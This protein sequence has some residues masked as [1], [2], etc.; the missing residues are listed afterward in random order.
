MFEY[1]T[2]EETARIWGVT[3]RYV[4]LLCKNGKIEGAVK[5]AGSW[6]IPQDAQNPE[7]KRRTTGVFDSPTKNAIFDKAIELV[8]LYRYEVVTIKDIAREIGRNQATIYNHFTSKQDILDQIYDYYCKYFNYDRSTIDEL[9]P[10]MRSGS[11]VDIIDSVFYSFQAEHINRMIRIS[12]IIHTRQFTDPR[13]REIATEVMMNSATMYAK[14]AFDR[15]VEIGRVAPFDTYL[16]A[17]FCTYIRQGSYNRLVLDTTD[18]RN[19]RIE[20]H[21]QL[22]QEEQKFKDLAASLLVDLYKK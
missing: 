17:L 20:K 5:K 18:E 22:M 19:I 21:E 13:A 1:N 4:Q 14:E 7:D 10:I 15:A 2:A 16:L 6:F 11:L 3:T 9:E 8:S 12:K